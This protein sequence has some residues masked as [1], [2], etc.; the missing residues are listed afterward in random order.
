[1]KYQMMMA[2]LRNFVLSKKKPPVINEA[3]VIE[4]IGIVDAMVGTRRDCCCCLRVQQK[5]Q[6]QTQ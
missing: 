1:M 3:Q 2:Y 4:I 5:E 6:Q